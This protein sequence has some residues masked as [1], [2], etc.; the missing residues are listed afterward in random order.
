MSV[1]FVTFAV[2]KESRAEANF[3]TKAPALG[4]SVVCRPNPVP[5]MASVVLKGLRKRLRNVKKVRRGCVPSILEVE[6]GGSEVRGQL[7]AHTAFETKLGLCE[8][9]VL[10]P[11]AGWWDGSEVATSCQAR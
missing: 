8:I 10:K 3:V 11:K 1:P 9:L 2:S 6:T 7:Q 5:S 4:P